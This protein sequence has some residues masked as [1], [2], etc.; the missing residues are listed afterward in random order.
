M[1]NPALQS[2]LMNPFSSQ[3]GGIPQFGQPS[4]PGIQ[5]YG[6][7]GQ[8]GFAGIHPQQLQLAALLASQ[9][10][11]QLAGQQH[12]GFQ[13]PMLTAWLQNPLLIPILAQSGILGLHQ[14]SPFQ[15][16]PYQ[17]SLFQQSPFQQSPFQ[18]SPF[19]QSPFQQSPFQQSP[20]QQSPYQQSPFQQSP[21]QQSPFQQF[22][23]LGQ[24]GQQLPPQTWLGQALGQGLYGGGNPFAGRGFHTP[25]ISPWAGY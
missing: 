12:M 16:S 4:H 7:Q 2:Q 3:G 15:Q 19:Q 20:Y 5:G 22:G 1:Q 11:P 10:N 6:M 17:Q 9:S 23:Q 24:F 25:G 14:Q 18:Q 13:N 8:T 21:F